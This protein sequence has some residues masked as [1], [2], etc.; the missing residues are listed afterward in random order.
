MSMK[1]KKQRI[2]LAPLPMPKRSVPMQITLNDEN[3]PDEYE[4]LV[5]QG[6]VDSVTYYAMEYGMKSGYTVAYKEEFLSNCFRNIL[7]TSYVLPSFLIL[8]LYVYQ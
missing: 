4:H 1:E 7:W 2:N 3:L 6:F 8:F 5:E